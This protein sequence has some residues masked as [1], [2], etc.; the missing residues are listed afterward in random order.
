MGI[1]EEEKA[2][3]LFYRS[4]CLQE[5][6]RGL[7]ATYAPLWTIQRLVDPT[8]AQEWGSPG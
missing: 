3:M 5:L 1:P 7:Q 2:K 6:S 4:Q 8:V